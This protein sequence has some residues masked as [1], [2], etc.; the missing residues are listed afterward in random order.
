MVFTANLVHVFRQ[1]R[2]YL[3]SRTSQTRPNVFLWQLPS[4][5]CLWHHSYCT[6]RRRSCT[7]FAWKIVNCNELILVISNHWYRATHTHTHGTR[8]WVQPKFCCVGASL[9][10]GMFFL[11]ILGTHKISNYCY[12]LHSALYHWTCRHAAFVLPHLPCWH[13]WRPPGWGKPHAGVFCGLAWNQERQQCH[14]QTHAHLVL[15]NSQVWSGLHTPCVPHSTCSRGH[16]EASWHSSGLPTTL[17]TISDFLSAVGLGNLKKLL[18][19]PSSLWHFP[20]SL[21]QPKALHC[22]ILILVSTYVS[23]HHMCSRRSLATV[24]PASHGT[25]SLVSFTKE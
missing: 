10:W 18:W 1:K 13:C 2:L 19:L 7:V 17:H 23:R 11:F 15:E 20:C 25:P 22:G 12:K 9:V 6:S 8:S 4:W 24:P 16:E 14:L 5:Q 3:P 21:K